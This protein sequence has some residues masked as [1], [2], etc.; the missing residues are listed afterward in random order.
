M[1]ATEDRLL[2]VEEAALAL[3]CSR[4]YVYR[5]IDGVVPGLS[6]LPSLEIGRKKL[7]R[8]SAIDEWVRA[9][10]SQKIGTQDGRTETAE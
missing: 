6:K 2:T 3:R 1:S 9:N 7:I 10:E 4:P 5:L 8:R